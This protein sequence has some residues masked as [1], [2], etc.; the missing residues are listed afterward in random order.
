MI[1]VKKIHIQTC[2]KLRLQDIYLTNSKKKLEPLSSNTYLLAQLTGV[3]EQNG[4]TLNNSGTILLN[5]IYRNKLRGKFHKTLW[6][7]EFYMH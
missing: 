4:R 5:R 2:R 6:L 3:K 7:K 1:K